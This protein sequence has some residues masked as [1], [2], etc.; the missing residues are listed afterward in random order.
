MVNETFIDTFGE[1]NEQIYTPVK[2]FIQPTFLI[3]IFDLNGA[4]LYKLYDF[5]TL[6]IENNMEHTQSSSSAGSVGLSNTAT[7]VIPNTSGIAWSKIKQDYP[8]IIYGDYIDTGEKLFDEILIGKNGTRTMKKLFTGY[9]EEIHPSFG[10]EGHRIKVVCKNTIYKY[11]QIFCKN[12]IYYGT[13][14]DS[15][16]KFMV[17]NEITNIKYDFSKMLN[18]KAK[19]E[20]KD[21]TVY[22]AFDKF[23]K[24]IVHFAY[25]NEEDTLI[26]EPIENLFPINEKSLYRAF[27][28][29]EQL[30]SATIPSYKKSV[31]AIKVFYGRTFNE[32]K[33]VNVE[34]SGLIELFGERIERIYIKRDISNRNDAENFAKNELKG[35]LKNN[36]TSCSTIFFPYMNL[37]EFFKI[38]Y[39]FAQYNCLFICDGI[40][41]DISNENVKTEIYGFATLINS[42]PESIVDDNRKTI[43][44]VQRGN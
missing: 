11:K 19:I 16:L 41:H 5:E 12:K 21:S 4:E 23:R 20:I 38:D 42:I 36:T 15:I 8:I 24:D 9:I 37:K 3:Q 27:K 6:I 2:E 31:N 18:V 39:P 33:F 13:A 10:N 25:I 30:L 34:D 32:T 35:F 17:E 40:K 44:E 7:L 1:T 22:S 28:Y 43:L 14:K 26:L 29:G